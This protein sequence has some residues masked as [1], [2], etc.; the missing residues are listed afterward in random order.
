MTWQR[1]RT[2][3]QIE[4]RVQTITEAT[5]RLYDSV[6]YHEITLAMIAREAGFTRSNLYKYFQTSEEIFLEILVNDLSEWYD[7]FVVEFEAEPCGVDDFTERY[8]NLVQQRSR[9][10]RLLTLLNTNLERNASVE[11]L[12]SFKIRATE[13]WNAMSETL[14][15][16]L[17]FQDIEAARKFS[18]MLLALIIGAYPM[19]NPSL[20]QIEAMREAGLPYDTDYYRDACAQA[21]TAYLRAMT[22]SP[23]T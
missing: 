23:G 9:M 7:E 20:G 12:T 21:I 5:C 8:L 13:T 17:P 16:I 15:Q 19:W 10:V 3:E 6:P 18:L 11:K 22:Q 14:V 2:E 1:A 4:H